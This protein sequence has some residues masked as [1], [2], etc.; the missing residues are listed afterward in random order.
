MPANLMEYFNK[1]PM[2]GALST[3]SSDLR[4]DSDIFG[5]PHMIDERSG[6]I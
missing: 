3:S 4:V 5:S 6:F 1:T 2:L